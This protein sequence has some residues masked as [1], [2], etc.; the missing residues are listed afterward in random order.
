VNRSG[1]PGDGRH[2][3]G[4]GPRHCSRSPSRN[5]PVALAWRA[6]QCKPCW[7][8]RLL[9][10]GGKISAC[11][12]AVYCDPAA[13]LVDQSKEIFI[14]GGGAAD[15]QVKIAPFEAR[16]VAGLQ[17]VGRSSATTGLVAAATGEP[18]SRSISRPKPLFRM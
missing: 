8:R 18:N 14:D 13:I 5:T 16:L 10:P 12:L 9:A 4:H 6:W 17:G 1:R 2:S 15:D 11:N 7:R 3:R